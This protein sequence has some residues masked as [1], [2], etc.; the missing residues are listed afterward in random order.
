MD[1]FLVTAMASELVETWQTSKLCLSTHLTTVLRVPPAL[2]SPGRY[3]KLISSDKESI[4]CDEVSLSSSRYSCSRQVDFSILSIS[5]R[6]IGSRCLGLPE[7]GET[8]AAN[9]QNVLQLY[10]Q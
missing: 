9:C 5:W 6:R 10:A 3:R 4:P 7:K 2:K 8:A 1:M